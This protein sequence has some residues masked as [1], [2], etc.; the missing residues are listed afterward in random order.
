MIGAIVTRGYGAWGTI[1]LIVTRGYGFGTQPPPPPAPTKRGGDDAKRERRHKQNPFEG[2]WYIPKRKRIKPPALEEHPAIDAPPQIEQPEP[3][4]VSKEILSKFGRVIAKNSEFQ[5]S[6]QLIAAR[7]AYEAAKARELAEIED[8]E[9]LL[10][11]G[12]FDE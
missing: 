11:M 3:V 8:E 1:G 2:S 4:M 6:P 7:K 10:M 12:A 5:P 9:A